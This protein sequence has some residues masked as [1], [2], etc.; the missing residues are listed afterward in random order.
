ML[1]LAT[2][3]AAPA[4]AQVAVAIASKGDDAPQHA[5]ATVVTTTARTRWHMLSPPAT[6]RACTRSLD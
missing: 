2:A 3:T 6:P 5:I 1:A 4:T